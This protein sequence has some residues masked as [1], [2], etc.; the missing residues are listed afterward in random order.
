MNLYQYVQDNKNVLQKEE[1]E[2]ICKVAK[3]C[4][5]GAQTNKKSY[6]Q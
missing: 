4:P 2:F 6:G 1:N 5:N 3:W